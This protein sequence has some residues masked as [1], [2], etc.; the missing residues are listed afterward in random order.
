MPW[1]AYERQPLPEAAAA[2]V[3]DSQVTVA[4]RPWPT[5][6]LMAAAPSTGSIFYPGGRISYLGY[7][8]FMKAI[9][10]Q[11]CLV[12]PQMP[13]NIAAFNADIANGIITRHPEITHWMIGGPL[14]G[15]HD[16]RPL[17]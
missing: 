6:T 17:C 2:L 5:F 8:D 7:S 4:Q 13:F 9:A 11:S 10:A 16:G 1:L 3:S 15:R 14:R 12:V